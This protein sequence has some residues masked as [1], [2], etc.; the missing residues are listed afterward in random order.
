[1]P[2]DPIH[3]PGI[4]MMETIFISAPQAKSYLASS[5]A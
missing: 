5:S 3:D 2:E 4:L 1:M